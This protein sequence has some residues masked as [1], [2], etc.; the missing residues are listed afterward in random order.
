MVKYGG[1][2]CVIEGSVSWRVEGPRV[3]DM[4]VAV[5]VAV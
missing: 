5:E 4:G 3:H 1:G 2:E